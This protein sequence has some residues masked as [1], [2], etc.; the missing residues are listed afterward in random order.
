MTCSDPMATD[1]VPRTRHPLYQTWY[2]MLSRCEKPT[3]V[4]FRYYGARGVSVCDAWH[5]FDQFVRDVGAPPSA[6]HSLDRYPNKRG[7]Y[8]PGN[9]RWATR[10]EQSRN[11]SYATWLANHSPM[12]AGAVSL[13]SKLAAL[14]ISQ[15]KAARQIGIDQ[16]SLSRWLAGSRLPDLVSAVR[17]E[18]VFGV[19]VRAWITDTQ[20]DADVPSE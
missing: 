8:E 3:H 9:V 2:G 12:R 7:N 17:I 13:R 14:D 15:H 11:R 4:G 18:D 19:P 1:R 16:G 6:G 20:S 5:D 10:E